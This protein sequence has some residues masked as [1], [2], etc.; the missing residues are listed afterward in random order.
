[1]RQIL[2]VFSFL[3]LAMLYGCS[4][5][6]N[7]LTITFAR[8][9]PDDSSYFRFS[10][11][12]VRN[13]DSL[14]FQKSGLASYCRGSIVDFDSLPD[15]NYYLDYTDLFGKAI[16]KSIRLSNQNKT[17]KIITDSVHVSDYYNKTPIQLLKDD[18]SYTINGQGGCVATLYTTYTVRKLIN[19]YYLDTPR[20]KEHKLSQAG[21]DAIRQ[22]EAELLA[23]ERYELCQSTGSFTYKIVKNGQVLK[24]IDDRTCNWHGLQKMFFTLNKELPD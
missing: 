19:Q 8:V 14:I 20:T 24:S 15:G 6:S 13:D 3:F 23:I 5:S 1:M 10:H 7:K 18:E 16:T 2:I 22:F 4:K 21:I 12:K 17:L 11:F 9:N